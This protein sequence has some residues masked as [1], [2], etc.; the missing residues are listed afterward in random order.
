MD[1]GIGMNENAFGSEALAAV[2]RDGIAVVE[3]AIVHGG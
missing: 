3:M 2:A 1:A